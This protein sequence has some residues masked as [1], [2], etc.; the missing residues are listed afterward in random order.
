ML[1]VLV[2]CINLQDRNPYGQS[3]FKIEIRLKYPQEFSQAAR[4][5]VKVSIE[6]IN[7]QYAYNIKTDESATVRA[8]LPLGLYRISVNDRLDQSIFN[9][10]D[11]RLVLEKDMSHIKRLMV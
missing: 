11:E 1:P 10:S 2:S 8:E 5:G 4:E 6:D 9:A 7:R 3:L